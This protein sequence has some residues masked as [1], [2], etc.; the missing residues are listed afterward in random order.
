MFG[1]GVLELQELV[2]SGLDGVAAVFEEEAVWV[3]VLVMVGLMRLEQRVGEAKGAGLVKFQ[4]STAH[5]G[6]LL[7]L[8]QVFETP[9]QISHDFDSSFDSRPSC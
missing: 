5:H 2:K 6:N 8:R 7:L 3:Q 9:L 4:V 1:F